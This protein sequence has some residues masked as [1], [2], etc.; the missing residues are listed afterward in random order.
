MKKQEGKISGKKEKVV[1]LISGGIDSPVAAALAAKRYETVPLHFSLYPFYCRGSFETMIAVLKYL[2]KKTKFGEFIIYP[3]AEILSAV[4]KSQNRLA[5]DYM[6]VLCRKAMLKAAEKICESEGAAGI[7][8]G[9]S[10]AQKA[11]Q[12]L[13]NMAATSFGM[14]YPVIRPLLGMDKTEIIK[15]SKGLEMPEK[16]VGCCTAT[17]EWPVTKADAKTAENLFNELGL[18]KIIDEN[19]GKIARI[20]KFDNTAYEIL[21]KVL[22]K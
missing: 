9:E 17:P 18:Q 6:C 10:V 13:Q 22:G 5:R 15:L 19:F 3:H 14:K 4:L 20:K 8:T 21:Q 16:H 11:S 1:C 2:K 12:T 7:V